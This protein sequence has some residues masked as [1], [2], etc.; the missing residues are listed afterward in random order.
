MSSETLFGQMRRQGFANAFLR[1]R[2]LHPS[3]AMDVEFE[4]D[5]LMGGSFQRDL[6]RIESGDYHFDLPVKKL[7]P[8]SLSDRKRT[9]FCFGG[10]QKIM[11]QAMSF[12][13][14]ACDH[15]FPDCVYSSILGK[16][17]KEYVFRLK[18]DPSFSQMYAVKADIKSYGSSI[19]IGI[20]VQKLRVFFRNDPSAFA[21]FRWLLERRAFCFEGRVEEGDTSA[22]PG[23]PVH[24][25]FTNLYLLDMDHRVFPTCTAYCRYSDDILAFADGAEAA[26]R[27]MALLRAETE[28]VKLCFNEKK[29]RIYTPHTR[30]DHMGIC[31]EDGRIDLSD[32]AIYKLKRKQRIRAKRIRRQVE[33]GAISPADGAR[34]LVRLTNQTFFGRGNSRELCWSRWLFPML[35]EHEGLHELD[36]YYQR[37]LRYILTGKWSDA[38]YRVRYRD[39]KELGYVS[40]VRKFYE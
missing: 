24:S 34:C 33:D 31:Y 15:R 36:L 4:A 20:L 8:K 27:L 29:T 32:Y 1:H 10:T 6:K 26:E 18:D 23:V 19:D 21:F 28:G 13:L 25:F 12:A 40:L 7:I 39:L 5:Y 17:F 38:A 16:S 37:C 22:L 9:V 2:L 3:Y 30:F 14:H 35:T 11:L